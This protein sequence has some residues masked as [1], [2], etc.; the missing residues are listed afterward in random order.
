MFQRLLLVMVFGVH[1]LT[2]M[3]GS[4]KI[5]SEAGYK[6]AVQ[7]HEAKGEVRGI[8]VILLHGKGGSPGASQYSGFYSKLKKAGYTVMAPRMPYS[9]F[10]ADY[11]QTI[12]VINAAV[13]EAVKRG[14]RV[15]VA[16]HSMGA[17]ISL[18]YGANHIRKEVIGI[19][20]IALGHSPELSR[21]LMNITGPDVFK[22][23]EMVASGKGE[24]KKSFADVNQGKRSSIRM[25]AATYLSYYDPQVYPGLG[26]VLPKIRVPVFWL[27][28]ADDRLTYVYDAENN[29]RVI[30]EHP[31]SKYL[32][33]AGSH[34]SVVSKQ[35]GPIIDWLNTL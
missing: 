34:K 7:V 13:D 29:F 3:A 16:G 6:T 18:H 17:A 2:A 32:E 28:G 8:T 14:D 5:E 35:T 19:M 4:L 1:S 33:A 15:V 24:K 31:K 25:T 27:S 9:R 26:S 21:K 10:D 11:K 12:A 22:A 20:P 23:R 30:P